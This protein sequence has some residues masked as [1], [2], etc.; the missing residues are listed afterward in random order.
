MINNEYGID[1]L[2][3]TVVMQKN[4]GKVDSK[5]IKLSRKL[6]KGCAERPYYGR[7]TSTVR[8]N[9]KNQIL[10]LP[11]FAELKGNITTLVGV[12]L[13]VLK[14]KKDNLKLLDS[15]LNHYS[16]GEYQDLHMHHGSMISGV[17]WIESA[18][19]K[20]FILQAPWHVQQP[21]IPDFVE[22]NL[23]SSHHA[24]YNS[25][26]GTATVFMSHALHQTIPSSKERISLSFNIGK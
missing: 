17:Y 1:Y 16:P 23:I 2:F 24:E 3:P 13:D 19:E 15:W 18:G 11:E 25:V 21:I 5:I 8:D 7:C 10:D 12:M 9:N 4:F 6:L 14:I 22:N 20:D 26:P